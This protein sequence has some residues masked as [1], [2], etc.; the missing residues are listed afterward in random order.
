LVAPPGADAGYSLTEILK[1]RQ[2]SP[3]DMVRTGERFYSSLGFAPLPDTFW[4]RSPFT[5]PRDRD[6]VCHASAW[7]IDFESDLRIK[8]CIEQTG[9]DFSTLHHELGHNF[10]QRGYY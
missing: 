3:V 8:M 5:R 4:Q 2:V 7:D 1:R 6:V 10:Y 9:D